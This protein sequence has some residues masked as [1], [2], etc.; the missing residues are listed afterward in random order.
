MKTG[1]AETSSEANAAS[2]CTPGRRK[3]ELRP[4]QKRQRCPAPCPEV[5]ASAVRN[6][7]ELSLGLVKR[8][9]TQPDKDIVTRAGPVTSRTFGWTAQAVRVEET[10]GVPLH[11]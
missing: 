9:R 10:N 11:V 6:A 1:G 8:E 5:N 4:A 7:A 3:R 2:R